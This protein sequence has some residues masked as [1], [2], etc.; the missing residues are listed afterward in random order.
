MSEAGTK[1]WKERNNSNNIWTLKGNSRNRSEVNQTVG[2]CR[3]SDRLFSQRVQFKSCCIFLNR[4]LCI[5]SALW[6]L[7]TQKVLLDAHCFGN[8]TTRPDLNTAQRPRSADISVC[9]TLSIWV[10]TPH[11]YLGV[12]LHTENII[13]SAGALQW[14]SDLKFWLLVLKIFIPC[15]VYKKAAQ[16]SVPFYILAKNRCCK[17]PVWPIKRD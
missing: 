17:N 15:L 5:Q 14:I 3:A 11:W 1:G 10:G 16:R 2:V 12:C 4:W 13:C 6:S 8:L 9:L 7:Q